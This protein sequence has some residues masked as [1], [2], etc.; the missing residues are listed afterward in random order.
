[1]VHIA[2]CNLALGVHYSREISL[3][4]C[5]VVNKT[6][7]LVAWGDKSVLCFATSPGKLLNTAKVC[8]LNSSASKIYRSITGLS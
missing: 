4:T 2:A 3:F 6:S 5:F 8:L 7:K 1:M